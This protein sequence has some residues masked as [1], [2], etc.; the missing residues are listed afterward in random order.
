MRLVKLSVQ[1]FQCIET[2]ELELGPH[3]NILYGPNDLGKSSLAW[4][5]R[6]VLLLQHGSS[7]AERFSSWYAAGEPRVALTFCDDSGRYWRVTKTFGGS[8]GRSELESSKDGQVFTMEEKAR[9]VDE[10]LRMLL[11]WGL[12]TP[13]GKGRTG[14]PES[15]LTHV[16][17]ADQAQDSVRKILF[18]PKL[19]KD[20]DESGRERLV[21]ALDA[22]AQDPLFK[23]ILD[24]AAGSMQRAFTPKGQRKRS[25]GSP[26]LE[27]SE[28]IKALRGD[29]DQFEARVKETALVETRIRDLHGRH[30]AVAAELTEAEE[31]HQVAARQFEAKKQRDVLHGEVQS[32]QQ[33]IRDAE[34][35]A[36]QIEVASDGAAKLESEAGAAEESAKQA[37]ARAAQAETELNALRRQL[38]TAL[39]DDPDTERRIAELQAAVGH[40]E[41]QM[42]EAITVVGAARDALRTAGRLA[43]DLAAEDAAVQKTS[44]IADAA[45]AASAVASREVD[46][47]RKALTDAQD[48][49]RDAR[50]HDR[51]QARELR[52]KD[53]ENRALSLAS[54][55]AQIDATL[56]RAQHVVELSA[57]RGKAEAA[58]RATRD[59]LAATDG[60]ITACEAE[61]KKLEGAGAGLAQLHAYG[62]FRQ[63]REELA[64][65]T[66]ARED[67]E[68]ERGR[69]VEFRERAERLQSA[70]RA[71]LP[72]AEQIQELDGLRQRL[73]VAEAALGG[74]LSVEV[75]PKRSVT[76]QATR[77]GATDPMATGSE[78]VTLTAKRS[79]A[80][81]IDDWL[82]IEITAGEGAARRTA[83]DLRAR[84]LR[85]GEPVLVEHGVASPEELRLARA[86]SDGAVRDIADAIREAE[87]AEQRAS[88]VGDVDAATVRDQLTAAE[89]ELGAAD[90]EDLAT[91][92]AR[93]GASWQT[94][95]RT[96]SIDLEAQLGSSRT[97]LEH[98]RAGIAKLEA[99]RDA[100]QAE[101]ARLEAEVERAQA[102]LP[103]PGTAIVASC[104]ADQLALA[105]E[106][107]GLERQLAALTTGASEEERASDDAVVAAA[108]ALQTAE[109][110][111]Q[112]RQDAAQTARAAQVRASTRL[113]TIRTTARQ[114]DAQG[115]WAA[116]LDGGDAR[117]PVGAW[118][119]AV[120]RA[121][122]QL[123]RARAAHA[124]ATAASTD[125]RAVRDAAVQSLRRKVQDAEDASR[126]ARSRIDA[127]E[128]HHKQLIT[129]HAA[130]VL[131]LSE[132][133]VKVAGIHVDELRAEIAKRRARVLELEPEIGRVD[134]AEV[135]ALEQKIGRLRAELRELDEELAKA[136]GALEQVGGAVVR[137]RLAEIGQAIQQAEQREHEVEV[138]YEAWRLLHDTLREAESKESAHLGRALAGPVGARFR[139]LTGG[140]YG[141]IELGAQLEAGGIHVAG[142]L[143]E[144]GML[145][146]GTQDQLATLLRVCIAQQLR[147]AIILDD[148]L[149]QSDP[150]RVAWFNT[151]LR[152]AAENVQIILI[153]CRPQEVLA[154]DELCGPGQTHRASA[155]GRVHAV[156]MAAVIRR[157]EVVRPTTTARRT[158]ELEEA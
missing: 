62:R 74:G 158:R 109:A 59:Q 40:T 27:A 37:A 21:A 154:P 142:G 1:R 39:H 84:W 117:L 76:V 97:R 69:A 120:R 16:L 94:G 53:L 25:A 123:E 61:H 133:K 42:R 155:D 99:Q 139:Q 92:F 128:A 118:E 70:V 147:S 86:R 41:S 115:E 149:T 11:R 143:R 124:A 138:E 145:S 157:F 30:D 153:T 98:K 14:V 150:A 112:A 135:T 131:G 71:S 136:K 12:A 10:K 26:W 114:F 103:G 88:L 111:A 47:A 79:I 87:N 17:L 80:L 85:E 134:E 156:D 68:R 7:H 75:R 46:R 65:A 137:E 102:E 29:K 23:T 122:D 38:D 146:A 90:R 54:Q 66:Q 3:L 51:A 2:A 140:R 89:S 125:A 58:V 50:S 78:R 18:E 44:A 83:A 116:R 129:Q 36:K 81:A 55:R 28:R 152:E 19:D 132:M 82:D 101:V 104:E 64:K 52:R 108:A 151:T 34:T 77:D 113:D 8:S 110:N 73:Q 144:I 4:A 130:A 33:R 119:V 56:Q 72:T 31:A 100:H 45:D 49:Q 22:F 107:N 127:A 35:M 121:E 148:H 9:S 91:R 105:A 48:R 24:Q 60:E 63:L 43:A 5:I 57:Q 32:L 20:A 15:F 13:G 126:K 6:A 96:R 106:Q 95:L 67:A 93:L 141:D